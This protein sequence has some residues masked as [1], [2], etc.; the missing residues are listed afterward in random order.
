MAKIYY[1]NPDGTIGF[2]EANFD[3][4]GRIKSS[5]GAYSSYEIHPKKPIS[6]NKSSVNYNS[7]FAIDHL[8]NIWKKSNYIPNEKKINKILKKITEKQLKQ[9]FIQKVG[10]LTGHPDSCGQ[11]CCEPTSDS[12]ENSIILQS[13]ELLCCR[14]EPAVVSSEIIKNKIITSS[15]SLQSAQLECQKESTSISSIPSDSSSVFD[16]RKPKYGYAR[17]RYGRVQ[18]RDCYIENRNS[19]PFHD[20]SDYDREDDHDSVYDLFD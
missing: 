12:V 5:S 1:T 10:D 4:T 14:M 11:I 15:T 2:M 9:Y 7:K 17:D 3:S 8:I 16:P 6:H 18:E 19:N 13:E 20:N